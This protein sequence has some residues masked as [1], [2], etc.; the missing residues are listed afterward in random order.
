MLTRVKM[1]GYDLRKNRG[2]DTLGVADETFAGGRREILTICWR[3]TTQ[4]G[5][6]IHP[7]SI[8]ISG[9]GVLNMWDLQDHAAAKRCN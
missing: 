5:T 7:T 8:S 6:G 3:L 1:I 9:T 2:V 4:R